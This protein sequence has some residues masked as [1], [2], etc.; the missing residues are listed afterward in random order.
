M[1]VNELL[2]SIY[3]YKH[4]IMTDNEREISI[5]KTINIGA[6]FYPES[7]IS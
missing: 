7:V 1:P 3:V 5:N 2:Q 4:F 6:V